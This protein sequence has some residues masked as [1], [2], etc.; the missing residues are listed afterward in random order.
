MIVLSSMLGLSLS[1]ALVVFNVMVYILLSISLFL[2]L[3]LVSSNDFYTLNKLKN[4]NMFHT[5]VIFF[6]LFLLSL[7][8][9]PPLLGFVGKLLLYIQLLSL[10]SY[11]LFAVLLI[12]NTF[13]LYFYTQNIRFVVSKDTNKH[14]NSLFFSPN[15]NEYNHSVIMLTMFFNLF[16][17]FFFE[18]F[19]NCIFF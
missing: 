16:G 11:L 2:I 9:M 4:L 5:Y 12:L 6:L 17:I 14:L 3:L 8:G 13:V 10:H 19:L 7:A 1:Y 15:I 18:S